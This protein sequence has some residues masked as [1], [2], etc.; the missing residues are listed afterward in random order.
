MRTYFL[1]LELQVI[2]NLRVEKY[3][4]TVFLIDQEYRGQHLESKEIL[5]ENFRESYPPVLRILS[6]GT[7]KFPFFLSIV[8]VNI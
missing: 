6:F 7:I 4:D 3:P 5:Y 2:A 1:S 8:A